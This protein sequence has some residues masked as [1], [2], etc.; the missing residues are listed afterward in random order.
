MAMTAGFLL[1]VGFHL[2][3]LG[4]NLSPI[5]P[6]ADQLTAQQFRGD[7][8]GWAMEI[9]QGNLGLKLGS[10]GDGEIEQQ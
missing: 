4:S 5:E 1:G 10:Q 7:R 9:R 8:Q 2:N 3:D 6:L